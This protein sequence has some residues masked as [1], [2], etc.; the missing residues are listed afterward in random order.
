[1]LCWSLYML[2]WQGHEGKFSV[3][4]HASKEKAVHLSR[5]FANREIRSDQVNLLYFLTISTY[6]YLQCQLNT[7]SHSNNN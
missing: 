4:V 6:S 5:Y 2:Y 7:K 1:M 3:Y